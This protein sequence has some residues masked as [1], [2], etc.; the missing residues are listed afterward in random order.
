MEQIA[1]V[2]LKK[3]NVCVFQMIVIIRHDTVFTCVVQPLR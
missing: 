1:E 3:G 2:L